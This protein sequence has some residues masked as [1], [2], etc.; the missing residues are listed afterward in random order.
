[1]S[2]EL[3]IEVRWDDDESWFVDWGEFLVG[4]EQGMK[5]GELEEVERSLAIVLELI[6]EIEFD[7]ENWRLSWSYTS[8]NRRYRGI[9][10]L[11]SNAL[12]KDW[13]WT[14]SLF[15]WISSWTFF[16]CSNRLWTQNLFE[17]PNE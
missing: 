16:Y 2:W 7:C 15:D 10:H 13:G 14:W 17:S 8:E 4:L 3:K 5:L 6:T 9:A 11:D 1:M 12:G